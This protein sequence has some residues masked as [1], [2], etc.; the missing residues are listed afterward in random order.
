MT[1]WSGW[2]FVE[3]LATPSA[4]YGAILHPHFSLLIIGW[5]KDILGRE[6]S[7][8]SECGIG[9]LCDFAVARVG[10]WESMDGREDS[11]VWLQHQRGHGV[12]IDEFR[13]IIWEHGTEFSRIFWNTPDAF[14]WLILCVFH[15]EPESIC[16]DW[17]HCHVGNAPC[18]TLWPLIWPTSPP[19]GMNTPH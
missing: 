5:Q 14:Q 13:G 17:L 10:L 6:G 19:S 9:T 7:H 1:H 3:K 8:W 18:L 11:G 16:T 2:S 12:K 15:T 4:Q